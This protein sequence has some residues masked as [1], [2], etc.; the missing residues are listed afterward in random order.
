MTLR[1]ES[2]HSCDFGKHE[3]GGSEVKVGKRVENVQQIN[4]INFHR[5]K[6]SFE[7]HT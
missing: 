3:L 2:E 6:G 1:Q 4:A 5:K 7:S